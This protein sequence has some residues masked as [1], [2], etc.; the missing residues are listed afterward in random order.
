MRRCNASSK[1]QKD[2]A[3]KV[4]LSLRRTQEIAQGAEIAHV[5]AFTN[6]YLTVTAKAWMD[7]NQLGRRNLTKEKRDEMIRRLA[8]RGVDKKEIA[9]KTDLSLRSV[10][11]IT[12]RK[13]C[14][15]I[16]VNA[17]TP[18]AEEVTYYYGE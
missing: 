16:H 4:G 14:A 15:E 7:L 10:Q 3:E 12:Q 17:T 9:E 13:N 8:A 5:S 11:A 18:A 6:S 2:I 1:R